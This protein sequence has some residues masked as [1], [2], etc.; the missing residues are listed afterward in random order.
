MY[1]C[2]LVP[3]EI[4]GRARHPGAGAR[5]KCELSNMN[6]RNPTEVFWKSSKYS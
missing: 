5:V 6:A 4:R 3:I 1:T 2:A